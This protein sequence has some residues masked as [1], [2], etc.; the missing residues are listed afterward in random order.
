[1]SALVILQARMG[2]TRLPG[3]VLASIEGWP[4]L[5]YCLVRLRAAGVGP[6]VLATTTREEDA[7][8][9][10]RGRALGVEVFAGDADDVLARFAGVAGCHR[11]APFVIRATADNPFV[12]TDACRRVLKTLSEGAD[13]VVEE[14]LPVGAAVE[15]FRREALLRAQQEARTA[16]DREHVTP[17]MR[18]DGTLSR[19]TPL[20]PDDVRAPGV[21][22]TVDTAEDLAVV[23]RVAAALVLGGAD[24]RTARLSAVI[25]AAAPA[26]QECA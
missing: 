24:P 17:W 21:R 4:L 1:M 2:S 6:V 10:A 8:L 11:S 3:K 14:G 5:E 15:G 13:Y 25:A 12:D 16:Y 22:L 20:A 26:A 9:L 18:R 19:A 23:R 7:P